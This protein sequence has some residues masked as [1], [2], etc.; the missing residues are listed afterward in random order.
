MWQTVS[1]L[2][3]I[4]VL[5]FINTNWQ[6]CSHFPVGYQ[7]MLFLNLLLSV[8]SFQSALWFIY[9]YGLES[10]SHIRKQGAFLIIYASILPSCGLNS[11]CCN[12]MIVEIYLNKFCNFSRWWNTRWLSPERKRRNDGRGGILPP[13]GKIFRNMWFIGFSNA[14]LLGKWNS[15]KLLYSHN[16]D[17]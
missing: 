5:N 11:H 12:V 4:L 14:L 7:Q 9:L 13:N 10:T 3:S 17:Y 15:W 8:T 2:S 1:F 6:K 16:W